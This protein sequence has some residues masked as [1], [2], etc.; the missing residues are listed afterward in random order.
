MEWQRECRN[1]KG[2]DQ[3]GE[4][5]LAAALNLRVVDERQDEVEPDDPATC[6]PLA[7]P[8]V[9]LHQG[10]YETQVSEEL[11]RG[12]LFSWFRELFFGEVRP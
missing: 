1:V 2:L 4:D 3:R 12:S 7:Q 6:L 10:D 11:A 8:L 9:K 5:N